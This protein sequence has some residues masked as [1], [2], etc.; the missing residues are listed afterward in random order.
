MEER[1]LPYLLS[2]A[3]PHHPS[4]HRYN[5]RKFRYALT[6]KGQGYNWT[7]H[8]RQLYPTLSPDGVPPTGGKYPFSCKIS[9]FNSLNDG[10]TE[11]NIYLCNP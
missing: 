3:I 8:R 4:R 5:E 2:D 11:I 10:D 7:M 1:T 6:R 9:K